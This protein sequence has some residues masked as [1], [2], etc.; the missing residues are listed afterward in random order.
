MHPLILYVQAL[1]AQQA[2][3]RAANEAA[4]AQARQELTYRWQE[5]MAQMQD[6]MM[7]QQ[8]QMMARHEEETVNLLVRLSAA[9]AA[10]T[11]CLQGRGRSAHINISS[12]LP[13]RF[14]WL[15]T[16]C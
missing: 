15:T 14:T 13:C 12:K 6:T 11:S 7:Q 8:Q 16:T 3:E 5:R 2:E 9:W 4:Y 10:C 1:A